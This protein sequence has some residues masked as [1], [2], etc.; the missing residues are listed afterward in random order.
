MWTVSG[1]II[2]NQ[3]DFVKYCKEIYNV[4]CDIDE[5]TLFDVADENKVRMISC[6]TLNVLKLA[7]IGFYPDHMWQHVRKRSCS[8]RWW[9]VCTHCCQ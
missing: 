8:R 4:E 5:V 6:T 1:R 3:D 7:N 9:G 2:G